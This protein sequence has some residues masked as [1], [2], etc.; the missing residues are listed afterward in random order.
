MASVADQGGL[1]R[2]PWGGDNS[3]GVFDQDSHRCLP[4]V[5]Y[6]CHLSNCNNRRFRVQ[7]G[8]LRATTLLYLVERYGLSLN[9]ADASVDAMMQ[10]KWPPPLSLVCAWWYCP[11]LAGLLVSV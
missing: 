10:V 1:S 9:C 6:A 3:F 4:R 5:G 11:L 7:S 2:R 8:G